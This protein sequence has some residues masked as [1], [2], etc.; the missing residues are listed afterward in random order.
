MTKETETATE[1]ERKQMMVERWVYLY[2]N[3]TRG[4]QANKSK[5]KF[6]RID[7]LQSFGWLLIGSV[8]DLDIFGRVRFPN[9]GVWLPGGAGSPSHDTARQSSSEFSQM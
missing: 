3:A 5:R 7:Q 2:D 8:I 4:S 9:S 1:I 6:K